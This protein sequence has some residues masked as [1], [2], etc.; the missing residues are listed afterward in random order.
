MSERKTTTDQSRRDEA[1]NLLDQLFDGYLFKQREGELFVFEGH[2]HELK[3]NRSSV[4]SAIAQRMRGQEI[5]QLMLDL[6]ALGIFRLSYRLA[7][8]SILD[9]TE[10][11]YQ[12][13]KILSNGDFLMLRSPRGEL[14]RAHIS[15]I[16]EAQARVFIQE[17]R[18]IETG[19]A[20][21]PIHFVVERIRQLLGDLA[22]ASTT[23]SWAG[24]V[25]PLITRIRLALLERVEKREEDLYSLDANRLK[26]LSEELN[27][28]LHL[29]EQSD[30]RL[31]GSLHQ[32]LDFITQRIEQ[33]KDLD[34]LDIF[35]EAEFVEQFS[36]RELRKSV[37]AA[38]SS[39]NPSVEL[40]K[41]LLSCHQRLVEMTSQHLRL[42]TLPDELSLGLLI[43]HLLALQDE[44]INSQLRV[45]RSDLGLIKRFRVQCHDVKVTYPILIDYE[46]ATREERL[47]LHRELCEHR[48]NL[49]FTYGIFDEGLK[50]HAIS[51]V[52]DFYT[53]FYPLT[54]TSLK[55]PVG[56]LE[57]MKLSGEA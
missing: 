7:S 25:A 16:H 54:T 36:P 6:K 30:H 26:M 32:Q 28:C 46:S 27:E 44:Y 31:S 48:L 13:E 29:L 10:E 11:V 52:N 42:L 35:N 17:L 20:S 38:L 12:I 37:E 50:K 47:A 45:G 40:R 55:R 34:R 4:K 43:D 18:D 14:R 57:A 15:L 19:F 49:L 3:L 9:A 51:N 23:M 1:L 22:H 5:D 41:V 24:E 21:L 56:H 2:G 39:E 53:L 33:L 8:L